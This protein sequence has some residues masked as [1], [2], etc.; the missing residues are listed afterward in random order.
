MRVFSR[1][2]I[3]FRLECY[4]GV[5]YLAQVAYWDQSRPLTLNAPVR[6]VQLFTGTAGVSPASSSGF[7]DFARTESVAF[8]QAG[9]TPVPVN[10]RMPPSEVEGHSTQ[11]AGRPCPSKR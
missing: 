2:L 8:T 4:R 10:A 7:T 5:R 3:E 11:G 6:L 9:G 1:C